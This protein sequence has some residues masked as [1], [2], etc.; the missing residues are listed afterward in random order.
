MAK[1]EDYRHIRFLFSLLMGAAFLCFPAISTAQASGEVYVGEGAALYAQTLCS[2]FG[3]RD[4]STRPKETLLPALKEGAAVQAM[5]VQAEPLISAGTASVFYPHYVDT[6]VIA[7]DRQ[8]T[9][10]QINGWEGLKLSG[11]PVSI[12][13][14]CPTMAYQWAAVS[15]GLTGRYETKTAHD[16]FLSLQ[17]VGLSAYDETDALSP[18]CITLESEAPTGWEIIVPEEGTLCFNVGLLCSQPLDAD[19]DD[20]RAR[21]AAQGFRQAPYAHAAYADAAALNNFKAIDAIY[22]REIQNTRMLATAN[23]AE[24]HFAALLAI[25]LIALWIYA[26]RIRALASRTRLLI[27]LI[28]AMQ[29]VWLI[30]RDVKYLLNTYD[31]AVRYLWYAFYIFQVFIPIL[32]LALA[33]ALGD[34]NPG[35]KHRRNL[36]LLSIVGCLLVGLVFTNDSHH[37]V[38]RLPP[39]YRSGMDYAYGVGYYAVFAFCALLT[40]L[41]VVVLV[42]KVGKAPRRTGAILTSVTLLGLLAYAIGYALDIPLFVESDMTLVACLVN[43]LFLEAAF[44]T[45][46]I[47]VNRGYHALFAQLPLGLQL[48][49]DEGEVVMRTIDALA[50]EDESISMLLRTDD[51]HAVAQGDD[52]I[53]YATSIPGG[54][55]VWQKD[56]LELNRL[57]RSLEEASAT[58]EAQHRQLKRQKDIEG[59]LAALRQQNALYEMLE[60]AIAQKLHK[61]E[62]RIEALAGHSGHPAQ[63]ARSIAV[64]NLLACA[65]KRESAM[66]LGGMEEHTLAADALLSS[67]EELMEMANASSL[68]CQPLPGPL[69]GRV[70]AKTG[71]LLYAYACLLIERALDQGCGTLL[72]RLYIEGD[73]IFILFMPDNALAGT[74]EIFALEGL[75]NAAG[76]LL[77]RKQLDNTQSILLRLPL[78][79]DGRA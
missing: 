39:A 20:I 76:G 9:D 13:T 50:L 48:L 19:H 45:G 11:L 37:L 52:A 38:F 41:S 74:Q 4:V 75:I 3:S 2:F 15:Y 61:I 60:G 10:I 46:L 36:M 16:Y 32:F 26:M 18:V 66:L 28:G 69:C 7:I 17:D 25:A 65:I 55:A 72:T 54:V 34:D 58:L 12:S 79:G 42:R 44:Q 23:F 71:R 40:T 6:I 51:S 78:G 73:D 70:S 35:R 5:H 29:I 27:T 1:G 77:Q 22:R 8:Q 24:H 56:V 30:I 43:L 47:P 21:L 67:L 68:V 31:S 63:Y 64:I 33:L 59:R 62:A 14:E 49:N 53:L 57:H